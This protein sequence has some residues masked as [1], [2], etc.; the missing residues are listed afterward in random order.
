VISKPSPEQKQQ[1]QLIAS[2]LN[3][4]T[5]GLIVA[6]LILAGTMLYV[7][8]DWRLGIGGWVLGTIVMMG[9]MMQRK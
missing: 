7:N 5:G 6:A 4:L 1:T 2:A 3:R 9:M 8:G